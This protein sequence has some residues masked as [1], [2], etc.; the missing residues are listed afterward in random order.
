MG[1]LKDW[2]ASVEQQVELMLL[3]A[4]T[5]LGSLCKS[6]SGN[7]CCGP[8]ELANMD[9]FCEPLPKRRHTSGKCS[10]GLV[11]EC[12]GIMLFSPTTDHSTSR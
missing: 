8:V 1:Y 10:N 6:S 9:E 7:C 11:Y 2:K 3:S 4:E 5:Q 12:N